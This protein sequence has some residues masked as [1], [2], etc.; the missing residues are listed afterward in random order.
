[1]GNCEYIQ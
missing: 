1:V